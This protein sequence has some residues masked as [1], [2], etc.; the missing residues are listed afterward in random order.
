MCC[1]VPVNICWGTVCSVCDNHGGPLDMTGGMFC[2]GRLFP[3][4]GCDNTSWFDSVIAAVETIG[5]FAAI[6]AADVLIGVDILGT[7]KTAFE[8]S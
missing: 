5:I 6:V 1:C 8:Y 2:C 3:G 7:V 4:N